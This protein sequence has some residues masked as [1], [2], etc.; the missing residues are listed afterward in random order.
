M[1]F[2]TS[3]YNIKQYYSNVL[4]YLYSVFSIQYLLLYC[5]HYYSSHELYVIISNFDKIIDHLFSYIYVFFFH[6]LT[7]LLYDTVVSV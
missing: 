3:L 4:T 6:S 2:T 1:I 7:E 5:F